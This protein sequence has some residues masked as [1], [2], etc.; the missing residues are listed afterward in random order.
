MN[1][2]RTMAFSIMSTV[3][4]VLLFAFEPILGNHQVLAF[5]WYDGPSGGYG[6]GWPG[7]YGGWG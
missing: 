1:T 7:Y 2:K 5:G 3:A 6:S 4:L